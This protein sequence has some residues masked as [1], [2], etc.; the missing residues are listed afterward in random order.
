MIWLSDQCQ[1]KRTT[2]QHQLQ[3][4]KSFFF[5]EHQS[6]FTCP[7]WTFSG[8]AV[9]R[10]PGHPRVWLSNPEVD[11]T[12]GTG[13]PARGVRHGRPCQCR[14]QL[15]QCLRFRCGGEW[16]SPLPGFPLVQSPVC[17]VRLLTQL[18]LWKQDSDP[19]HIRSG[20]EETLMSH[21]LVF[22]AERSRLQGRVVYCGETNQQKETEKLLEPW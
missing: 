12:L 21:L 17:L 14:L 18:F 7:G 2:H 4:P 19:S 20:P 16:A 10:W 9:V 8:R 1:K 3:E 15:H 13:W 11:K 5:K 6:T 22:E